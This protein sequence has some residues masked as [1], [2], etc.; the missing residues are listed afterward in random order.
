MSK[1]TPHLIFSALSMQEVQ[2]IFGP[3]SVP[4]CKLSLR[5]QHEIDY[6]QNHVEDFD[7][8]FW[9]HRRCLHIS[10]SKKRALIHNTLAANLVF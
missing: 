4:S 3:P 10:S 8:V 1:T 5:S 7:S 9:V 2:K 6:Q